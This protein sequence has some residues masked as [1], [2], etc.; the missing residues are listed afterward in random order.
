MEDE[1]EKAYRRGKRRR[2]ERKIFRKE[3]ERRICKGKVLQVKGERNVGKGRR[4][5]G[6]EKE[7]KNEDV[8]DC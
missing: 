2:T 8:E 1:K 6:T 7:N 5:R 4:R 3:E